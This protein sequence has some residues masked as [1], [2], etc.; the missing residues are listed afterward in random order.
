MFLSA[1]HFLDMIRRYNR[2]T[3]Q[4]LLRWSIQNGYIT[5]PKSIKEERILE[6]TK[7]FDF[8]L[9][10]E[11]LIKMVRILATV[12]IFTQSNVISLIFFYLISILFHKNAA[13]KQPLN[14]LGKVEV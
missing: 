2:S 6:N 4:I 1:I 9:A 5:I 8:S 14:I 10:D 12:T 13:P 7:V 11:D 3:A